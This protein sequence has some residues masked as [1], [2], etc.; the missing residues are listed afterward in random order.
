MFRH[1]GEDVVAGRPKSTGVHE[2]EMP[3]LPIPLIPHLTDN[4]A[5]IVDAVECLSSPTQG[6]GIPPL[7]VE[8][9]KPEELY[10]V[11]DKVEARHGKKCPSHLDLLLLLCI[12]P[13]FSSFPPFVF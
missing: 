1:G 13:V 12:L 9:Q 8:V 10:L 7:H 6:V 2:G 11:Q 3:P 5:S 4:E